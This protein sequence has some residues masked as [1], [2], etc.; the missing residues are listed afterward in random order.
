MKSKHHRK[1]ERGFHTRR[2]LGQNFLIDRAVI[3]DIIAGAE[4][5]AD[6]LVIEIGPGMGALT[7][8]AAARARR[9]AAIE[10]DRRLLPILEQR[11]HPLENVRVIPG[12]ILEIDLGTLAAEERQRDPRLQDVRVLGNLPYYITTP[13]LL[14]LLQEKVPARSITIMMQKEVADRIQAPPGSR[15]Y[16]A[17]SVTVQY[18]CKVEK[19]CEVSRRAFR[20]QPKVDSTVLRL[21]PHGE[22]PAAVRSEECLFRCVRAAFAARRKTLANSLGG[23]DGL[24][25]EGAVRLLERAGIDPGRRAETLSLTE[26][27]AL[28]NGLAD[29]A[30]G[31]ADSSSD[32]GTDS[33]TGRNESAVPAG[34]DGAAATT[35]ATT[36]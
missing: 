35:K 19:V 9:V 5:G 13:I 34:Q 7:M 22:K 23:L 8:A 16:G 2:S 10:I 25:K 11:L 3:D 28:A 27:A 14:K 21:R 30:A 20:P 36:H 17:L 31:S 24:G 32:S 18:Y 6:D 15:V 1:Q 4:I 12:D 33:G 26:F 29:G